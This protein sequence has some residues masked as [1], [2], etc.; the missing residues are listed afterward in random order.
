MLWLTFAFPVHP[1]GGIFIVIQ[2]NPTATPLR[3]AAMRRSP[4][5]VIQRPYWRHKGM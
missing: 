3:N 1:S 5:A 2:C 4:K